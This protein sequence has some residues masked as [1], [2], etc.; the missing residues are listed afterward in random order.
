MLAEEGEIRVPSN[1]DYLMFV[2]SFYVEGCST[3][4]LV[5][6]ADCYRKQHWLFVETIDFAH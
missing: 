4:L 6:N 3:S 2:P 1:I 5:L